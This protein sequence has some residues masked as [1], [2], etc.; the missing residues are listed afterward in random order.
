MIKLSN[1]GEYCFSCGFDPIGKGHTSKMCKS[2]KKLAGH[3]ETA[4]R[5]DRKGGSVA[6]KPVDFSL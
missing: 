3:D 2:K 5:T 4:T 6:N 1:I